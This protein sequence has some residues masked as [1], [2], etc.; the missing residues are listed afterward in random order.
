MKSLLLIIILMIPVFCFSQQKSPQLYDAGKEMTIYKRNSNIGFVTKG[1]GFTLTTYGLVYKPNE[2]A[3]SLMGL[4]FILVGTV[5][6]IDA[7]T[8]LRKAG[9]HLEGTS[10]KYDFGK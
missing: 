2:H 7:N 1:L 3:F 6:N 5:I 9:L 10:L 8:S 4:Y